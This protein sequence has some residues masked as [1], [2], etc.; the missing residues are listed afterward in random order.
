[1]L[2]MKNVARVFPSKT[3]FATPHQIRCLQN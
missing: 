1:M 3:I 2:D